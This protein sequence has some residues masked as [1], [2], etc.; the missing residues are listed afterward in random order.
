L[1]LLVR[2]VCVFSVGYGDISAK[3]PTEMRVGTVCVL[4]S[5]CLW[6]YIIGSACGIVSNLDPPTI[7]HYQTLDQL[8]YFIRENRGNF[9]IELQENLREF[10]HHTK[11]LRRTEEYYSSIITK[12]SP[13]LQKHVTS[14]YCG[15]LKDVPYFKNASNSFIVALMNNVTFSLF[16][17]E[18]RI[19]THDELKIVMR[20]MGSYHNKILTQG[21]VWGQDFVLG[22]DARRFELRRLRDNSWALALT[23][24][25]VMM[26][27]SNSLEMVANSYPTEQQEIN[28]YALRLAARTNILRVA[29]YIKRCGGVEQ[30]FR[31][32]ES[33]GEPSAEMGSS[34]DANTNLLGQGASPEKRLGGSFRGVGPSKAGRRSLNFS[35]G[36]SYTEDEF[37]GDELVEEEE[38]EDGGGRGGPAAAPGE[39]RR[40]AEATAPLAAAAGTGR[41]A[42]AGGVEETRQGGVDYGGGGGG[43]GGLE[44]RLARVEFMLEKL[45][46]HHGIAVSPPQPSG[47]A[48]AD[49]A[50]QAAKSE[51]PSPNGA[52]FALMNPLGSINPLGLFGDTSNRPLETGK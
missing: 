37:R 26:L 25:E 15:W 32:F 1:V 44:A 7:S 28:E 12:M 38:E 43:G 30:A 41:H 40:G 17:P 3:N 21:S 36:M 51:A 52:S 48:A 24:L 6:A 31:V 16:M 46:A 14:R 42:A 45:A 11:A 39:L 23:Y 2:C 4:M 47:G 22:Y 27:S 20:G 49:P 10:F 50:G 9:S 5:S 34:F 13:S 35:M 8:N 19:V 33:G 18:E 29:A